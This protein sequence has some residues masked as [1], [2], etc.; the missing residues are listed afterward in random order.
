MCRAVLLC[1]KFAVNFN[2]SSCRKKG[3]TKRERE[4]KKLKAF[5]KFKSLKDFAFM[6]SFE[7][8]N[9]SFEH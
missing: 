2:S 3:K 1:R 4:K 6:F 9:E 5:Y 8:A 7:T